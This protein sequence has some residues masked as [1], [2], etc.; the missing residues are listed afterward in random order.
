MVHHHKYPLWANQ[1]ICK[2][3]SCYVQP[4]RRR[5]IY[6]KVHYFT[7]DLNLRSW[8]NKKRCPISSTSRDLCTC[9]VW[10]CYS[11]WWRRC[12]TKKIHCLTLTPRLR[13]SRSHEMLS[14]PSTLCDLCTSKIWYCYIARNRCIYKKIYYLTL[15]LGS[16]SYEMLPSALHIMWPMHLHSLK[17][18]RQKV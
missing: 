4:V 15:T 14:K 8:T 9:K 1:S 11:Q 18:L 2:V 13:G 7:F 6:K 5:C 10:S 12:I 3:S 16:R 17:L